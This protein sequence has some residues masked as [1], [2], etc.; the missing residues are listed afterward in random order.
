MKL[1]AETWYQKQI[2]K[3]LEIEEG[4]IEIRK[5]FV[6]QHGHSSK[7]LVIYCTSPESEKMDIKITK[8]QM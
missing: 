3:G 2:E 4:K 7:V 1:A 5:E 6:H 8:M